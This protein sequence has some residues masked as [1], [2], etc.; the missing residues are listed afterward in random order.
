MTQSQKR[1]VRVVGRG[2]VGGS[3]AAALAEIDWAV[4]VVA[5][6]SESIPGGDV[7]LVLL[8]VPDS[9]IVEVAARV[10]DQVAVVAHV[11]GSLGTDVLGDRPRRAVLH[12][13]ASLPDAVTG[14]GRLRSGITFATTGD[15]FVEEVVVALG[16]R[17]IE[18]SD[19]QRVAYH[20]AATIASNHLVA[21]IDQVER[22][23]G[24][25]GLRGDMYL[26]LVRQTL[27]NIERLGAAAALTGPAARGDTA[28]LERHRRL[29][30]GADAVAYDA[31]AELCRQLAARR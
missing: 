21:L 10:A 24:G 5:G 14:S 4:D 9:A 17:R 2:R 18:V 15:E 12:P 13:L 22:V 25:A 7:D 8:C 31:M 3:F 30:G 23:A 11:A 29:L 6:H 28:T 26:P 1:R 19:A 27:D 16:G 20:A